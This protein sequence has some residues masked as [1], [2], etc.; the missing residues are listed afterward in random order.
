MNEAVPPAPALRRGRR[1]LLLIGMVAVAPVIA[2]YAAYYWFPRDKQANYGVLLPIRP[3]PE[4]EATTQGDRPFRVAELHGRWVLATAAPAACDPACE[5]ALYAMRQARTIQGREMDR[6][7]RVWFVTDGGEPA[8]SLL[9]QHP[10]LT[11]VR[12]APGV[13]A[14][15]GAGPDRIYLIDPLGNLVL[16]YPRDPDIKGV[17]ADLTRLL[18]ASRIG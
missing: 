2:S 11:V 5:K 7:A 13:L 18:K 14:A 10:D 16:A 1:T 3:A 8:A 4:I 17:A 12:A 15:W 6:I 9:T